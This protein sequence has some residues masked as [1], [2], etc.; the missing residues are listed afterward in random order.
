MTQA[1]VL[2]NLASPST[3]FVAMKVAQQ[4]PQT[5]D[6][7]EKQVK[8]LP[9]GVTLEELRKKAENASTATY[10]RALVI[11][12]GIF[13]VM[14][15][16]KDKAGLTLSLPVVRPKSDEDDETAAKRA[17]KNLGTAIDLVNDKGAVKK[18]KLGKSETSVTLFDVRGID[19]SAPKIVVTSKNEGY[20]LF[21][22]R[23]LAEM[24]KKRAIEDSFIVIEERGAEEFSGTANFASHDKSVLIKLH[25][26][27]VI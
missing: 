21:P 13:V 15:I 5:V 27:K 20:M 24:F 23:R 2:R 17:F 19:T 4:A 26:A 18:L 3:Q 6:V 7:P 22:V 12:D 25:A 14:K 8:I 16:V 10:C 11:I 1:N 9:R